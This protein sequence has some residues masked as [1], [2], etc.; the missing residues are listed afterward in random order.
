MTQT[1]NPLLLLAIPLAPL[2]GSA[3]AGLFG[4]RFFG[5]L[6]GRRACHTVT[7]LGV[8]IACVLSF[9]VLNDVIAGARF[10]GN[11]Y[12][13]MRLGDELVLAVG[14]LVDPL[15]AMMIVVVTFVSLMVHIYTIGYMEE[16]EG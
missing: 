14:F 1:L 8:A 4:T 15:T 9:I 3:L 16:D 10:N 11:I 5:N 6:L 7:I 2:L 12:E 13:W